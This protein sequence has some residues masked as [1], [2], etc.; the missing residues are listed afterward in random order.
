[1]DFDYFGVVAWSENLEDTGVRLI[2]RHQ[3]KVFD[4]FQLASAVISKAD[5]FLPSD[6]RLYKSAVI[7]FEKLAIHRLTR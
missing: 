3:L 4:G 2:R 7:E 6:K 5:L 1:M